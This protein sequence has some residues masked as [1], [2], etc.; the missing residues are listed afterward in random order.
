MPPDMENTYKPLGGEQSW[1]TQINDG[2]Q[3]VGASYTA[4]NAAAHAM[5]W[6]GNVAH[7]LGTLGG[8]NSYAKGINN[9]GQAV[10]NSATAGN[11]ANHATLLMDGVV[12]D[13][14][15]FLD[16]FDR[17]AGWLLSDEY[18]G[19]RINDSA[20]IAATAFNTPDDGRD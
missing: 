16:P 12:I 18:G 19:I 8:S 5:L 11:S 20:W 10:G 7:D 2:G 3:A 17:A 13:L 14:N 6:T 9:N 1:A 4:G 15:D